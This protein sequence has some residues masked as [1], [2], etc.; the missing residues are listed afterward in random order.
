MRHCPWLPT[1]SSCFR[2]LEAYDACER[3]LREHGK[4]LF[5]EHL[6]AFTGEPPEPDKL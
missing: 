4:R 2:L 6:D 3:E 1:L 5:M